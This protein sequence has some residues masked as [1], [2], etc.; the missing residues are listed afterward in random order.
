MSWYAVAEI[1]DVECP[2]KARGKE[3]AKGR[4]ER[5][6]ARHEEEMELV[7]RVWDGCNRMTNL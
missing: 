2:L 6:E 4:H 1:F 7:W 5:G 3:T